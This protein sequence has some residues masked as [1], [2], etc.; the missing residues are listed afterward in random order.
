MGTLP[1]KPGQPQKPVT[2]VVSTDSG[3]GVDMEEKHSYCEPSVL[4]ATLASSEVQVDDEKDD[5]L[6]E[7]L[8]L[9]NYTC[10]IY[11]NLMVFKLD[12]KNVD[13]ES[14]MKDAL[15]MK[16]GQEKG[17]SLSFVNIGSGMVP[18]K[19]GF[20]MAFVF[21]SMDETCWK[22]NSILQDMEV[23]VWDNNIIV[24][25]ALPRNC[26]SYKVGTNIDDMK[27][28]PLN[29][30]LRTFKK[31]MDKLKNTR[32]KIDCDLDGLKKTAQNH[33]EF[34]EEDNNFVS[35]E[36]EKE[37]HSSGESID[38]CYSESTPPESEAESHGEES[39][40]GN[41]NAQRNLPPALVKT[42]SSSDCPQTSKDL[43]EQKDEAGWQSKEKNQPRGILKRCVRR[44]FSESH[45]T[46]Q[47]TNDNIAWTNSILEA[48]SDQIS[49]SNSSAA[50]S[51]DSRI[52][53]D[54]P[55]N[56][57]SVR[58]NEVVQRQIFR[59]NSSIMKQK[60]KNE[61]KDAKKLRKR[62]GREN[63]SV[64]R[65]A[66]EG[67]AESLLDAGFKLSSSFEKSIL[68]ADANW[69]YSSRENGS[70]S[71]V[72][73]TAFEK[74]K[75]APKEDLVLPKASIQFDDNDS[76]TDSGVASSYDEHSSNSPTMIKNMDKIPE[77]SSNEN[78][79]ADDNKNDDDDDNTSN[80]NSNSK[81][82][83]ENN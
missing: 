2:R 6:K 20:K 61:K 79:L 60:R 21:E 4:E 23:E 18:M 56:K 28:Y 47:A 82:N 24:Q 7:K 22:D 76:H 5:D 40:R 78:T 36:E 75:N 43:L 27:E 74:F 34:E 16:N 44:C 67:D 83:S 32:S 19:Y 45:A 39:E 37:R 70:V 38:S 80:S 57:K 55:A 69:G 49:D 64:E 63:L 81:S 73:S 30:P 72:K 68:E 59:S 41:I 77:E 65:R 48:I 11:E 46:S 8:L 62:N 25:L 58:F 51:E 71:P 54:V 17:V 13:P 1:V 14:V 3:I 42:S 9:P 35:S 26:K 50:S 66:S 33:K 29:H 53:E 31:K 10:N 52:L 15:I 12:V